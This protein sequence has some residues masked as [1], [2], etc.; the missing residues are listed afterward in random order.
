V[1]VNGDIFLSYSHVDLPLARQL[2]WELEGRGF[3]CWFTDR[4]L[5]PGQP[6][7]AA[8][9]AGLKGSRAGVV[10]G[11]AAAECSSQVLRELEWLVINDRPVVVLQ[12]KPNAV[13]GLLGEL[14]PQTQSLR[15]HGSGSTAEWQHLTALLESAG[16]R[17]NRQ[18]KRRM[19][20]ANHV[21]RINERAR[22]RLVFAALLL[23]GFFGF[24]GLSRL[25]G[26]D[27]NLADFESGSNEGRSARLISPVLNAESIIRVAPAPAELAGE[28]RNSLGM[29]FAL[30]P[31]GSFT[32]RSSLKP[33]Q[34][35]TVSLSKSFYF[36]VTEVTQEQFFALMGERAS[37]FEGELLPVD[38]ASWHQA[39][40]FCQRLSSLPAE[41][42]AGRVYRLPTEGEW[43]FA[44]R[45]G[46][47]KRYF[48]GDDQTGLE[49]FAWLAVNSQGQPH[50]VGIKL[51]N[52][53]GLYD[54]YGNVSE[55]CSDWLDE[56]PAVGVV[57][58]RGPD[59]GVYKVIR[60]GRFN[61][62]LKEVHSGN[63]Q[64]ALPNVKHGFRVVCDINQ[65]ATSGRSELSPE[66][67]R[68][69]GPFADQPILDSSGRYKMENKFDR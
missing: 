43:E 54:M 42:E 28:L 15:F 61:T 41:L 37:N 2:V 31:P 69:D 1:Q 16:L 27:K 3:S 56:Y 68:L 66:F 59:N 40:E 14:L 58:P 39:L 36:G 30:I 46:S 47:G 55:W 20:E 29:K 53:W 51:P 17:P 34:S 19:G 18:L 45:A 49:R 65:P 38:G 33:N 50:A 24:A 6:P 48:F 5:T 62:I 8:I 4:D 11:S 44:A 57:D 52:P 32:R 25:W 21:W 23:I 10:I 9:A 35:F 64:F 22:V 26:P 7:L 12:A 67:R 60:G 63:R 13:A